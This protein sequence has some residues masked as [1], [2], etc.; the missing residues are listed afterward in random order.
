MV[1][2]MAYAA[3][4]G[5]FETTGEST[6]MP[7]SDFEV[8][9]R[10]ALVRHGYA[11]D[12]QVGSSG[13]RIDLAVRHPHHPSR[14]ILAVECDGRMYHMAK[15][16]RDRDLL[17]QSILMDRG[18]AIHRVWSTDW[19]A[20]PQAALAAIVM[21]IDHLLQSGATG[22]FRAAAAES[23][24]GELADD[25]DSGGGPAVLNSA[26]DSI[27]Q[28]PATV[29]DEASTVAFAEYTAYWSK[30]VAPPLRGSAQERDKFAAHIDQLVAIEGPV[31]YDLVIDRLIQLCKRARRGSVITRF[32][33]SCIRLAVKR[34]R[35]V[36]RGD[37]LYAQ[38]SP[39]DVPRRACDSVE[40]RPEQIAPEEWD[41]AVTTTLE[42]LGATE[43]VALP[44]YV[45]SGFGYDR[46]TVIIRSYV[47]EAVSRLADWSRI[48]TTDGL[49]YLVPTG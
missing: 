22:V 2:Y 23:R 17:R 47:D 38:G 49:L 26:I 42:R 18:W 6:G 41:A 36:K 33:E 1:E 13:F 39:T 25:P 28:D 48:K 43:V 4:G 45:A 37:F 29:L 44:R 8:A 40:R 7:D 9:V 10:D 12:C 27:D 16:A 34:G 31:H 46:T 14:Y 21:R 15:T 5:R 3:R 20:D 32:F 11:V 19:I 35:V 24:E 30:S